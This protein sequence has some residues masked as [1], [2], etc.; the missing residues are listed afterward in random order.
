[1]NKKVV[2][3]GAG[4]HAAA[5]FD[6]LQCLNVTVTALISPEKSLRFCFKGMQCWDDNYFVKNCHPKEYSLINGIGSIPGVNLRKNIYE[7]YRELGFDFISVVSPH[8]IV[9]PYAFIEDGAQI[10][11]NVIIQN[12]AL[13][14]SN[15]I[16]NTGSIIE[17][18][19]IIGAHSHIAP[20]VVLSGST[21]LDDGVHIGTGACIIQGIKV[22]KNAILGAGAV[23]TKDLPAN[24][25]SY[26]PRGIIA[27]RKG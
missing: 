4:G 9:S 7:K 10:L 2:I 23:L 13:I 3:I 6:I 26:P 22:G 25:I 18:D 5:I 24:S 8:A 27:E 17:H 16:I 11:H 20:G 1:M 12:G 21:I 14:K 15:A 19:C